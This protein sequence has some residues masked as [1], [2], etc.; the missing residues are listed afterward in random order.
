MTNFTAGRLC[1]TGVSCNMVASTRLCRRAPESQAQMNSVTAGR[2]L[3]VRL[4]ALSCFLF[5][6]G[7]HHGEWLSRTGMLAFTLR[8]QAH[9]DILGEV[10]SLVQLP[11]A[12]VCSFAVQRGRRD[13]QLVHLPAWRFRV[14]LR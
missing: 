6:Q 12:F 2:C 14:T 4:G 10:L 7:D 5:L 3:A 1:D 11:W 13:G 9:H 8:Q